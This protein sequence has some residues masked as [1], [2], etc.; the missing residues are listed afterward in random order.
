MITKM[1]ILAAAWALGNFIAFIPP[2]I[3]QVSSVPAATDRDAAMSWAIEH[4]QEV[5]DR[6]M[7]RVVS[8]SSDRPDI[9]F[10]VR[11][12]GFEDHFEF[13]LTIER[14]DGHPPEAALIIPH[15]E[16]LT[17]QLARLRAGGARSIDDI[18]PRI[19]LDRRQLSPS[20][21]RRLYNDLIAARFPLR[22][23]TGLFIHRQRLEVTAIGWSELR[24]DFFD[25]G[26]KSSSFGALLGAVWSALHAVGVDH[27][28][29][30]FDPASYHQT[31]H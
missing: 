27:A 28:G 4:R 7:P 14:R 6:L 31:Q 15:E 16:P 5:F 24:F 20:A 22:P 1:R 12:A 18:L 9:A 2:T 21:A 25:D 26:D 23:Q 13:L 17:V 30:A 3:A 11:A 8:F 10:S 19:H 29:L